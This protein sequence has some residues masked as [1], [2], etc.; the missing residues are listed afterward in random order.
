MD[1]L[2]FAQA[3]IEMPPRVY[4]FIDADG[5]MWRISTKGAELISDEPQDGGSER[6][7]A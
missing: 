2:E 1:C 7:S 4:F 5:R 6:R 3:M